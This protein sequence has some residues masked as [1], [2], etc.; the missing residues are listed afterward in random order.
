MIKY[1]LISFVLISISCVSCVATNN[2][3]N[4]RYDGK[5]LD[6][7]CYDEN[8]DCT[9]L[10]KF[11]GK[12]IY[13]FPVKCTNQHS[14]SIQIDISDKSCYKMSDDNLTFCCQNP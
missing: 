5:C 14:G 6:D 2:D 8:V 1:T 11:E 13:P 3:S 4:N 9:V 7:C 10:Q 12:Y